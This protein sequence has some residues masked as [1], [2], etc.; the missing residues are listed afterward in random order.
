MKK[1]FCTIKPII[2]IFYNRGEG[3][4]AR[5]NMLRNVMSLNLTFTQIKNEISTSYTN[6]SAGLPIRRARE[7]NMFLFNEYEFKDKRYLSAF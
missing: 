2:P 7:A 4:F 1:R 3:A 6:A 5:S